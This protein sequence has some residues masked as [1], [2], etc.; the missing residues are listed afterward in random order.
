[1]KNICE[2]T[3]YAACAL[4]KRFYWNFTVACILFVGKVIIEII[5]TVKAVGLLEDLKKDTADVLSMVSKQHKKYM[6]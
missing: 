4:L 3:W 6:S 2:Y 5:Q 1:M